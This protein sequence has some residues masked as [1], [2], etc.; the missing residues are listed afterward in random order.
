MAKQAPQ[1]RIGIH[2][3]LF[4]AMGVCSSGDL[5]SVSYSNVEGA[6]GKEGRDATADDRL[7][8]IISKKDG[9]WP[10]QR[11]CVP[12]ALSSTLFVWTSLLDD[13]CRVKLPT[14]GVCAQGKQRC[15]NIREVAIP[16][17]LDS[18]MGCIV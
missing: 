6:L 14:M 10:L 1:T 2:R 9:P 3:D 12:A 15:S 5:L 16:R 13:E 8:L 7:C 17:L 11:V 4:L 18:F